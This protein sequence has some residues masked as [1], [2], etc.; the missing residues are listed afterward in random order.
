MIEY[1]LD[2]TLLRF[3]LKDEKITYA[4]LTILQLLK[5]VCMQTSSKNDYNSDKATSVA[6]LI[7]TV[8]G[9]L[10]VVNSA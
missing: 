2:T 6:H 5:L 3:T 8:Q 7:A 1:H 9:N 10:I 4:L